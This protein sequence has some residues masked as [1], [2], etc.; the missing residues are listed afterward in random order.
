MKKLIVCLALGALICAFCGLPALAQ[1]YGF[2]A[3]WEG[4]SYPRGVA[5]DPSGNVY[6]VEQNAH[7]IQKFTSTGTFITK[8][9][10]YGSGDGQFRYPEGVAVDSS[11]NVYVAD[12]TNQRIQKFTSNGVF[13]TKWGTYYPMGV[14]VD[15]SGN[16]YVADYYGNRIQ[17]FTSSGRLIATWTLEGYAYPRGVAVDP[18][19]NVYVEEQGHNRIQKFTSTGTFIT[20]WGSGGSGDGQFQDPWGIAVDS[21]G[22]VYVA[23]YGNDRIQKFTSNGVFITKWGSRGSGDGQ[24]CYPWGV[25]V[26]SSGKNVYVSDSRD[27]IQKFAPINTPTGTNV[28]VQLDYGI[29]CT[30]SQVT[31]RGVTTATVTET[32]PAIPGNFKLLG[33]YYDIYT[34]PNYS[35]SG[36]IIISIPY[37]DAG[38]TPAREKRLRLQ[39]YVDG[40]WVDITESLDTTNNIIT[41]E[42][43]HLSYFAVIELPYESITGNPEVDAAMCVLDNKYTDPE[44]G[45]ATHGTYVSA[46]ANK[47]VEMRMAGKITKAE[48]GEIVKK[49]AQSSVN[50]P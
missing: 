23:D 18:S 25:A 4:F 47:I 24:F 5:V 11:G 6:V 43:S 8:W 37:D 49:A 9:G 2:V 28:E 45:L 40:T 27:R 39:H 38:L 14:A 21:S 22:N 19:G 42:A 50:M 15:P 36:P 31:A 7:R 34:R 35:Y 30:F 20:K 17:K 44:T 41:G 29:T 46:V 1:E 10:T 26:D 3:K 33:K 12:K 48:G 16:V 13:I 32:G